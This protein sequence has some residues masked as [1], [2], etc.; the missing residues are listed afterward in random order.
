MSRPISTE[1]KFR[2]VAHSTR[3][4]IIDLLVRRPRTAGELAEHFHHSRPVLS[5]HLRVLEGTGLVSFKRQ[6][7]ALL[8]ELNQN[9]FNSLHEW[10]ATLPRAAT[11]RRKSAT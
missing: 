5:K 3:R 1:S 7:A 6:G 2:A 4:G 11:A 8:Y 9:A 10:I